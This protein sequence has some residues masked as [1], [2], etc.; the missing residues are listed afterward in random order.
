M[1]ILLLKGP[2]VITLRLKNPEQLLHRRLERHLLGGQNRE[3]LLQIKLHHLMRQLIG[4]NAGPVVVKISIGQNILSDAKILLIITIHVH[5][6]KT[7]RS[8][9]MSA[10]S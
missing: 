10:I 7:V 2:H 3:F 4:R 6:S 5:S 1:Y 9:R 8:S